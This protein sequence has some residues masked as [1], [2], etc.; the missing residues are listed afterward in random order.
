MG[1]NLKETI[2]AIT[3]ILTYYLLAV[4]FVWVIP[5]LSDFSVVNYQDMREA[6]SFWIC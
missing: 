1:F 6:S 5:G 2:V 3:D 4:T